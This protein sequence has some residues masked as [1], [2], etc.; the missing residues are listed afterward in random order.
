MLN[1]AP[2]CPDGILLACLLHSIILVMN[3]T[4]ASLALQDGSALQEHRTLSLHRVELY[5]IT[6]I[7]SGT[8]KI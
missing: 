4:E 2:M 1:P 3:E 8:A 6:E 5:I 7:D